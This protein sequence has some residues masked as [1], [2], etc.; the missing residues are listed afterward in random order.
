MTVSSSINQVLYSGNGTTVLFPVN[1]YFLQDSHLQ[2]ILVAAN[3][4]E[5]VQTLTTNYTVTG[6]GNE[7]GGSITMLVAPPTGTQLIIVRNV[8]ATQETDY[9][10]NDPFPAESHERALDKLTMLVQQ[11]KLESDRALKVPLA[12]LPTTDT[13]LPIPVGNKLLAWNS[14]ASAIVNFDPAD[15][16]T[17]TGQQNSYAD[18]F[19]GN[20]VT[21]DF[22][23]TRNP[24]T[25]FNIDVSIN[26]VTQVPNV[27]YI[28]AA[29]TLTFTSAPPAVASQ[30]LARYSEVFTLVDGD[31]AN[32]RYLPA[33]GVQTNVQTKLRETVSVKDFGAVGDGVTDDTAAIQAALNSGTKEIHIT[34]GTY[35]ITSTLT[36]S[37]NGYRIVQAGDL[38]AVLLKDFSGTT[39]A[40]NAG[41]VIWE[42]CCING[43][44]AIYTGPSQVGIFVGTG[45]GFG[46]KLFNPRIYNIG[47]ACV[48]FDSDSGAGFSI[49][50]GLLEPLPSTQ[51]AIDHTAVNDTG[52]MGRIVTGVQ[53]GNVLIDFAYMQTTLVSSCVT[54]FLRYDSTTSKASVVG[55][56][57][58]NGV[59]GTIN[60][61]GIDNLFVGNI[62]AGNVDIP[63]GASNPTVMNNTF[64]SGA[65]VTN[66]GNIASA[67]LDQTNVPYTPTWTSSGTQPV[68]GNGAI[69]GLYDRNGKDIHAFGQLVIGSTTTF[70]TGAYQFG[71]P[72]PNVGGTRMGVARILDAGT[73]YYT[74]VTLTDTG[75]NYVEI[76]FNNLAQQAQQ[77]VPITFAVNDVIQW[78]VTYRCKS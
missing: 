51:A 10:A 31:A 3:G 8:P 28:L 29:T 73:V 57:I 64:A 44:G 45:G 11:N 13:E 71:L 78:D 6:A 37:G 56:R 67:T 68:L 72:F 25:V 36:I 21:T 22:T 52:P 65:V 48:R 42:N 41:E 49:I 60:I 24:G 18:V 76:T 70:G 15:V 30:V 12:S 54:N 53:S 62:V 5:T 7:A 75:Q 59:V 39:I 33:G 34:Q 43:Q 2:V 4:T 63:S 20:G 26:G 40:F 58:S 17:I 55:C 9:L 14:N 47:S 38:A 69:S 32:I 19:T 16:I 66:S 74:G 1:Y 35:R 27:D 46:S 23:L 77:G 61:N 50:S